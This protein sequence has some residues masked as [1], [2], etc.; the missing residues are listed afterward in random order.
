M[1][2]ATLATMPLY[3]NEERARRDASKWTRVQAVLA[4]LQ[5]A[6]FLVSGVLIIRF[7]YSGSG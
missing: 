4:P 7:L 2:R 1:G 6:V 5:F 3:S